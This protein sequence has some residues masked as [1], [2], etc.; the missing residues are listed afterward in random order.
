MN[1]ESPNVKAIIRDLSAPNH[2]KD[3]SVEEIAALLRDEQTKT[4]VIFPGFAA[5]EK[6][7]ANGMC[8]IPEKI[9]GDEAKNT[10]I[11][12]FYYPD[13]GKTTYKETHNLK[14]EMK[15]AEEIG[16]YI[17]K[18]CFLPIVADCPPERV[19]N[20]ISSNKAA[21]KMHSNQIFTHC[22]GSFIAETVDYNLSNALTSLGYWDS[23]KEYILKQ[24]LVTH[25]NNLSENL[26]ERALL[27]T[28]L[29][30]LSKSDKIR[31]ALHYAPTSIHEYIKS[32]PLTDDEVLF[33]PL[34][35]NTAILLSK[36]L[37]KE[38][39]NEHNGA[40]WEEKKTS[41]GEK[42]EKIA[43][44]VIKYANKSKKPIEDLEHLMYD[45]HQHNDIDIKY[46]DLHEIIEYGK[47]YADDYGEYCRQ[48]NKK[49]QNKMINQ[50]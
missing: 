26:G 15:Q 46:E 50:H 40:Q 16:N 45:A 29:E 41:S 47:E 17:F 37:T 31:E 8:K 6:R 36:Q 38:G 28:H 11:I 22:F 12:S 42:E 20:R 48:V 5:T 30:R 24:T 23:E 44:G 49:I 4:M 1:E 34:K 7:V 9:L 18:N 43:N 27:M 33:I 35:N 32:E 3:I 39:G 21:M 25:H 14:K 10:K 2:C 13:L 19:L